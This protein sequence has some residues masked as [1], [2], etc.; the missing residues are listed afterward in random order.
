MQLMFATLTNIFAKPINLQNFI[1]MVLKMLLAVCQ[2][3]LHQTIYKAIQMRTYPLIVGLSKMLFR[4][5]V[6]LE[7]LSFDM[8]I[9]IFLNAP[10]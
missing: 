8:S 7:M 6:Q 5:A 9:D 10:F 2:Q 4:S 1:L 3:I